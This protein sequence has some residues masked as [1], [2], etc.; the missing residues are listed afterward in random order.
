MELDAEYKKAHR[1][2]NDRGS[3]VRNI[4]KH[5]ATKT[6]HLA[7]QF[8]EA[9]GVNLDSSHL[10]YTMSTYMVIPDSATDKLYQARYQTGVFSLEN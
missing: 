1:H 4:T 9:L 3:C 7:Q 10:S 8:P 2:Y 5:A 6:G